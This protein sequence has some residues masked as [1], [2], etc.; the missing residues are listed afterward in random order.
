MKSV[1]GL[2]AARLDVGAAAPSGGV[3]CLAGGREDLCENHNDPAAEERGQRVGTCHLP[4]D[5]SVVFEADDS[6]I[7]TAKCLS[8]RDDRHLA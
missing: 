7:Y 8:S 5:S 6:T 2:F 3:R 1:Y 4:G